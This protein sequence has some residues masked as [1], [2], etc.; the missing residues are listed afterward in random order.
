MSE[1]PLDLPSR[2]TGDLVVVPKMRRSRRVPVSAWVGA[3]VIVLIVL[4]GFIV[5]TVSPY[6]VSEFVANPLTAPSAA[7]PFGTDHIGRDL[8]VRTFVAGRVDILLAVVG[9]LVALVIGTALGV[10][11]GASH[12]RFFDTILMRIV[13]AVIAFPAIVLILAL[14]LVIGPTTSLG[15]IP[16]GAPAVL[17]AVFVTHW[18]VF[19][20]LARAQT[21]AL[22]DLDF[23]EAASILGY[24]RR[25]I[26]FKHILPNVVG[27]GIAYAVTDCILIIVATAS[28]PFLG[29]GVQPPAPE[30]GNLM[31]EGRV[32]L[33]NAWWIVLF[34]G[35]LLAIT[36]V[37]LALVGSGVSAANSGTR[38]RA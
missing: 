25:R 18:A 17:I 4:A 33:S 8:F 37:C 1:S 12:N 9:A 22:R 10:A 15:P 21:L 29:A 36:G 20:R 35:L 2:T 5:P 6:G 19:A 23:V 32:Y 30:W 34:P 28:L 31:F 24:S 26:V 14:V 11:A 3:S 38:R 13:D 27:P 7:H 16:A